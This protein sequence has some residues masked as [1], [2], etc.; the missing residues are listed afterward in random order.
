[1]SC[2]LSLGDLWLFSSLGVCPVSALYEGMGATA[3]QGNVKVPA[4]VGASRVEAATGLGAGGPCLFGHLNGTRLYLL[5]A[6]TRA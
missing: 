1:M 4:V 2:S 6:L 3:F 5:F